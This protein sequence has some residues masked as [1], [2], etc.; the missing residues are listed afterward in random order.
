LMKGVDEIALTLGYSDQI[1]Q[2]EQ[3]ARENQPWLAP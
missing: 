1:Q 3:N 2:Y